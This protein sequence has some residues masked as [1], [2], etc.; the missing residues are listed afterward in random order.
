MSFSASI[1]VAN[2]EAANTTLEAA[3]HGQNN[4]SVPERPAGSTGDA[5]HAGM[6]H[7]AND[8]VFQAAVAAIPGVVLQAYGTL[9]N[10]YQ[11]FKTAHAYDPEESVNW[12]QNPI[13]AGDI[14]THAGKE[15]ESLVDYNVWA[16]PVAWREIV[17]EGYPAWVQPTGSH[18]AYPLGFRVSF[19][20]QNWENTGSSANVWQPGVFGWTVV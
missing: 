5:T 4:F 17:A 10:G 18:D 3:G 12:Y 6:S 13:M 8:P 14:R 11:S 7:L 9:V 20:G 2:L 16:P 15:W 19:N 1:P